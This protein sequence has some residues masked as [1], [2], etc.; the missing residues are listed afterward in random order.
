VA[1]SSDAFGGDYSGKIYTLDWREFLA[2]GREHV[3]ALRYV[4]ARG[5]QS[6]RPFRLGGTDSAPARPLPLAS[7]VLDSPFNRRDYAL[8]GYPE[9][10]ADLQGR[11]LR[12]ASLEWRFPLARVER[13]IMAPPLALHQLSGV[14]FVDSGAVWQAGSSPDGYRTGAGFE[15]MTDTALFY[16]ARFSLR[17]GYAHGFDTGG[18]DQVYL[19]IGAAF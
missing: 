17:L 12:L 11:R 8:R 7:A 6:P 14:V 9:G 13:G 1:E 15:L 16:F 4:E 3:L 5:T 2:L 19:R 10:R 18:R